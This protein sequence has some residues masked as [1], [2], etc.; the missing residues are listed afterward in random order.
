MSQE[1]SVGD[2]R[3][4]CLSGDYHRR[5]MASSGYPPDHNIYGVEG[6][7]RVGPNRHCA[8]ASTVS[9]QVAA[10]LDRTTSVA[11]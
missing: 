3:T 1:S 8:T 11:V 5:D 4:A 10:R 6:A 7:G 2:T 9:F